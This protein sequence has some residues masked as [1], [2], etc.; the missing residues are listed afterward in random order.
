MTVDQIRTMHRAAPFQPFEINLA[1]GRALAVD[2]P[3]LLAINGPGRT[4]AVGRDDGTIE[5]VDL[6][7]VT[8]LK[9][10]ANGS[11]RRKKPR[12]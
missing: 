3:E 10:R 6:L 8:G 7:L 12:D 5:I 9:P 4:I 11:G 1:D 2:H